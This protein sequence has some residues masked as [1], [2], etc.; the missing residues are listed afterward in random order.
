MHSAVALE[1]LVEVIDDPKA[2]ARERLEAVRMLKMSLRWLQ[3]IIEAQQT[4][5]N[6]R[7]DIMDVLR[8]YRRRSTAPRRMSGSEHLM[9]IPRPDSVAA[10]WPCNLR[11]P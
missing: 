7:K 2:K 3:D 9:D 8:T 1:L 6:L 5:P 11:G 10:K 4:A